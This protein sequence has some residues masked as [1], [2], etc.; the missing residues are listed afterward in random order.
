MKADIQLRPSQYLGAA[1]LL[2]LLS[3]V[4][5]ETLFW[6]HN[7]AS[8]NLDQV[9]H[10]PTLAEPL[11]TDQF[12]RSNLARL[13]SALQTSILMAVFSV[14]TSATLGVSL[15]VVAGWKRGWI[16]RI[17]SIVVNILLA[18][19]GLVLVLLFGALVPGSFFILYIAISL[20]LWVEYFRVIRARTITVMNSPE[21]EASLLYGFGPWYVFKRH[22]WPACKK[23]IYTLACFGAGNSVL[24]LASIG[25]VYVGLRPPHAE[26][27]LMMVEL[28]PYYSDAAWVLLQ[29]LTAVILLVLGF[30]LIAGGEHE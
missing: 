23:D 14:L 4:V 24:A 8:Q 29:P 17:L 5:L 16:D 10:A 21:V 11:G 25:F 13:S 28:F 19:P 1:L 15:G 27:G 2:F 12:G 30:H 26:L 3:L 9:F 22:L 7:P 6:G 20:V 18:L